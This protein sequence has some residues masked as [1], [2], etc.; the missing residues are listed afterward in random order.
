MATL[1]I[2]LNE[3]A[4]GGRCGRLAPPVLAELA[5]AHDLTVR[6]TRGPGHGVTLARELADTVDVVVSVG[7]DG[8]LFEVVNGLMAVDGRRPALA[9]LPL[10]TSGASLTNA[11]LPWLTS[12]LPSA[13]G[14]PTP[15]LQP[16]MVTVKQKSA[17]RSST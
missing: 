17:S 6:R 10:G 13:F 14:A 15:K 9:L 16:F 1:G 12:T 4:G 3:A 8:T 11:M 7:G 2:I 5:L